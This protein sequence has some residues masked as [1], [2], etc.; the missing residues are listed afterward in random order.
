MQLDAIGS[1][2]GPIAY[3]PQAQLIMLIILRYQRVLSQTNGQAMINSA[4]DIINS[5]RDQG[6]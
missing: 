3:N 2:P 6:R 5:L 4:N 1:V